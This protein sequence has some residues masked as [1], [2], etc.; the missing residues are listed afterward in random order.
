MKRNELLN[1]LDKLGV[2]LSVKNE[3]LIIN[4]PKGVLTPELRQSV[5]EYKQEI[6]TLLCETQTDTPSVE[7][8]APDSTNKYE[9]FP[10]T[11][12]QKAYWIGRSGIFEL[13]NVAINGYVEF[14]T[15]NIDVSRLTAAWQKLIDRHDML[16]AIVLPTGEQKILEQV[17]PY[18]IA[19]LDLRGLETEEIDT[20]LTAIRRELSHQIL[21]SDK[22]PLFDIRATYLDNGIVR[23]HINLDL[24]MMDAASI[25]IL[26]QEWN[27]VYNNPEVKLP[28]LTLSFRDYIIS[29]NALKSPESI[30][31]SRNYW[32]NRLDSLPP[33]PELPLAF[34]PG[35]LKKYR[36]K[37]YRGQLQPEI[38]RK[39]KQNGEKISLTPSMILLT[40]FAEVLTL[41]SKNP[42][43]TLNLTVFERLSLHPEVNQI[44][45][46]FT[47]TI[48]LPIDN[49]TLDTITNRAKKIKKQLLQDLDH[50]QISGIEVLQELTRRSNAG[51][52][53]LMPIVFTSILG[54]NSSDEKDLK[55]N[56][57]GEEVYSVSQTPQVW[58]DHQVTEQ[59][60]GL[61]FNWDVVEELFP[62]GLIEDM[63]TAY[64][65]LLDR[66]AT[67]D[68]AWVETNRKLLPPA[69][70]QQRIEINKTNTTV[71]QQTL[72]GLF[73]EQAKVQPESLA[74]IAPNYKLTYQEL[75]R[76]A[77]QLADKLW[78]LGATANKLIAVVMEKGWEQIVAVLGIL[79]S[80]AAYLPIDPNQ[81]QERQWYLLEQAEV[82]LVVT[83]PHLETNLSF[84]EGVKLLTIDENLEEL[85]E[86]YVGDRSTNQDLAYVI[87]TS[88]STG[89][90]KGVAINHRGAVNT[91][92]D[93]NQRFGVSASDRILAL[94]ALN[95]DLSVYDIFG[96]L[97]AGGTIV[98]P[99][100]ELV[101]DPA[102]W[103]D[104][105]VATKVTL[106]NSVP[107]LMQMLV[108]YLSTQPTTTLTS[109][110]LALLSGDWL[111]LNLPQQI[112]SLSISPFP[113]SEGLGVGSHTSQVQVVSLGEQRKHLFG[114]FTILLRK[115]IHIGKVSP[116][117][118]LCLTNSFMFSIRGVGS[119]RGVGE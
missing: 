28:P 63:F 42:Y 110:R 75:D 35:Q 80:G 84:P 19:Q 68:S 107:A 14:E 43:F 44:V 26:F 67:S 87:Y 33:A 86:G 78:K 99:H 91:I 23:L 21:S 24:L 53:A 3:Q 104:L 59:N 65:D 94:S 62:E 66:L 36:F 34:F 85:Q 79:M 37:R 93:I 92:L 74:V 54:L 64:C 81:P 31:R 95:F 114:Q 7:A 45:G 57:L 32:F 47:N 73:I 1:E 4:A 70:L 76:R 69:Q 11:D 105:I 51:L 48:L 49:S 25:Q 96:I 103:L 41:W 100:P 16:R 15:N 2:K 61:L 39:L 56:F 20:K 12:I 17:S 60:G 117:E 9:P 27:Q 52:T 46:D 38:C 8:I 89:K 88:G 71:S 97:A 109:L 118:N 5:K 106:W 29:K 50:I 113:S 10:L 13:G 40:A 22:W 77:T 55:A 90:P 18:E 101:K 72:H 82:N 30:E 115:S 6:I 108:E 119:S 111:P 112:Q 102:H 98:I 83:Q 58:L 116:M